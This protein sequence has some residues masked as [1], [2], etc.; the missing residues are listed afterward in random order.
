MA[1]SS[2]SRPKGLRYPLLS[3]YTNNATRDARGN[4]SS[5]IAAACAGYGVQIY[6]SPACSLRLVSASAAAI[7]GYFG[8]TADVIQPLC[9]LHESHPVI[10]Q[11]AREPSQTF[12]ICFA[13]TFSPFL[14]RLRAGDHNGVERFCFLPSPH[15]P[16]VSLHPLP[17]PSPHAPLAAGWLPVIDLVT[18][19]HGS[20][21]VGPWLKL[22]SCRGLVPHLQRLYL[23]DPL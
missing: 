7:H 6:L 20:D 11:Y 23:A 4:Q 9:E 19:A 18:E 21:A 8:L 14:T 16:N 15:L 22:A 2:S 3:Q 12:E 1:G 10:L 13:S 17:F 5:T